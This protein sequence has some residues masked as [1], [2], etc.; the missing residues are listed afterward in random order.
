MVSTGWD[1]QNESY[2]FNA[3]GSMRSSKDTLLA[4][5]QHI[6]EYFEYDDLAR[7]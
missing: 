3:V 2:T 4:I 1:V 7:I 6:H 5:N